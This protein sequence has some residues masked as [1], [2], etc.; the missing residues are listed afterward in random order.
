MLLLEKF[1]ELSSAEVRDEPEE[2][3]E[4][5]NANFGSKRQGTA[6]ERENGEHKEHGV[7][8]TN[9]SSKR[10]GAAA[11][12]ES[13]E[14]KVF[15]DVAKGSVN[16]SPAQHDAV[17]GNHHRLW[18]HFLR[19]PSAVGE[20]LLQ[21]SQGA[22]ARL[23]RGGPSNPALFLL[24]LLA[25]VAAVI[26]AVALC[27]RPQLPRRQA[28]QAEARRPVMRFPAPSKEDK[29]AGM[30]VLREAEASS[31]RLAAAAGN[32]RLLSNIKLDLHDR[33]DL[34]DTREAGL[35]KPSAPASKLAEPRPPAQDAMSSMLAAASALSLPAMR[36]SVLERNGSSL[37]RST[38]EENLGA[39]S[40]LLAAASAMS[41]P[42]GMRASVLERN[43][44]FSSRSTPE[45]THLQLCPR[46]VVPEDSE[47]VFAVPAVLGT[48]RQNLRFNVVNLEGQPLS[49]IVVKESEAGPRCGIFLHM[50]D[51]ELVA[52]VRS[53]AM[54]SQRHRL[55]EICFPG[56][57]TFCSIVK[58]QSTSD[59]GYE[60]LGRH[61]RK[62]LYMSGNSCEKSV[63]IESPMGQL[64]AT[65][66][67]R[68]TNLGDGWQHV[69]C[70]APQTDAGLIL[71]SLLAMDKIQ[72]SSGL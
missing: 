54:H 47:F 13:G 50:L 40:S 5:A 64:V 48:S 12:R 71:C 58:D 15:G 45:E 31:Q 70:V 32:P 28:P 23:R 67:R 39:M 29:E 8:E 27:T 19:R 17:A 65:S 38:P 37:A 53:D 3:H 16:S 21:S 30:A 43:G 2:E 61:G 26:A 1:S 68:M 66:E 4:V 72:G 59:G 60:L 51:G 10:H 11:E 7:T 34:H 24:G 6:A 33:R 9:F 46:L 52:C 69:I 25:V 62:L 35:C 56:G 42:G 63:R 22:V 18:R 57:H 14:Y 44:S 55:P 49:Y 36:G 41:L 20:A